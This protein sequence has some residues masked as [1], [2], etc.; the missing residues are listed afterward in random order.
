MA[1]TSWWRLCFRDMMYIFFF[2]YQLILEQ[3]ALLS[4]YQTSTSP[5][6]IFSLLHVKSHFAL[7]P[8]YLSHC[9]LTLT[10]L[11]TASC[12]CLLLYLFPCVSW[13]E[14]IWRYYKKTFKK[15]LL[16]GLLTTER[17]VVPVRFTKSLSHSL[18]TF[19]L[20]MLAVCH[21]SPLS[22]GIN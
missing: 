18:S 21:S 11:Q 1:A 6:H 22:D 16:Q 8:N 3:S 17:P 15:T 10:C 20:S 2:F 5:P 7:K 4:A 19:S 14:I 9:L 13:L 12:S